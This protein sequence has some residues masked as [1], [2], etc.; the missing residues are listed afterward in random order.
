MALCL[1][2]ALPNLVSVPNYTFSYSPACA[3]LACPL[4]QKKTR[5]SLI[6]KHTLTSTLPMKR[7]IRVPCSSA[8][9]GPGFD[10]FGLALK[11]SSAPC[12]PQ[13]YSA[14]LEL[15]IEDLPHESVFPSNC[16]IECEGEGSESISTT[17]DK[18]YAMNDVYKNNIELIS[19]VSLRE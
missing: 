18:K 6:P 12:S 19:L 16:Q 10:V 17:V 9:V 2:S 11:A 4:Q 7:K 8:N 13:R 14:I 5:H 3:R 1:L 15:Q